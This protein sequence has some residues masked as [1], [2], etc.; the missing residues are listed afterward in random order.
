M[1][2]PDW[3]LNTP[4]D[5]IFFDCD[6]TLSQIEG[7]DELAKMN[8]VYDQ[9]AALTEQ[10]MSETGVNHALYSERLQLTQPKQAQAL[11]V[12]D[13]YYINLTQDAQ[14]VINLLNAIGKN[15]FIIS[16]GNNP[17]VQ[18]FA[19]KLGI[20]AER[21]LAVE[22][23]FDEQGDY[24]GYDESCRLSHIDGKSTTIGR[25]QSQFPRTLL[26]GDGLN[27]LEAASTVT[28]FVGFAGNAYRNHVAEQAEFFI[29]CP[30]LLPL[31]PLCLTADEVASLTA[32]QMAL[33]QQGLAKLHTDVRF[34]Q[35]SPSS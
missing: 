5:A 23:Y 32:H 27:D 29:Q 2:T 9:V 19:K 16:A 21:A 15:L 10:A 14:A 28:R 17:S 13:Q 4:L 1:T 7:I 26:V 8:H 25:M 20:P 11:A 18:Q 34:N 35:P 6:G 30:S 3:Q 12:A 22:L 24:T 31:L 33:Y